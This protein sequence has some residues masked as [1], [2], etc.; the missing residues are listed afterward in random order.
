MIWFRCV[1]LMLG[2]V[3]SLV[4]RHIA[5][6]LEN[7]E[8]SAVW[9]IAVPWRAVETQQFGIWS[10]PGCLGNTKQFSQLGTL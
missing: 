7:C 10:T 9:H 6:P 8:N 1:V 2:T 4:R 3:H 5:V